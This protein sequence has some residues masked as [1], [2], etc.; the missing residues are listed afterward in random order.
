MQ[1]IQV[2][3]KDQRAFQLLQTLE[4]LNILKIVKVGAVKEG[5]KL[6]EKYKGVFTDEDADSFDRHTQTSRDEW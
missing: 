2:E 4:D 1:T 6:S 3:I 5:T